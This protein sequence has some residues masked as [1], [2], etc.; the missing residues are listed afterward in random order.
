MSEIKKCNKCDAIK[1][2]DEF[3]KNR[4]YCKICANQYNIQSRK[5][6]KKNPPII[7]KK[8]NLFW[9]TTLLRNK[10]NGKKKHGLHLSYEDI[11]N[12]FETQNGKCFYSNIDLN[13]KFNQTTPDQISIDRIDSKKPYEKNNIVLCC[14]S[15]NLAKNKF[16]IEDFQQFLKNLKQQ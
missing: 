11:L 13:L 6:L 10:K 14:L 15:L 12:Q 16:S 8:G 7:D 2:I 5:K 4:N 9:V 3:K 1:K